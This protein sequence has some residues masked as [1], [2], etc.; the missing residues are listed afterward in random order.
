MSDRSRA[1]TQ[2]PVSSTQ[3]RPT[4]RTTSA[5]RIRGLLSQAGYIAVLPLIILVIWW[6]T[7]LV[8]DSAVFPAPPESIAYLLSDLTD[9]GFQ[10]SVVTTLV[11]LLVGWT[12]AVVVGTLLGF[13]LGQSAFWSAVFET[14]LFALYSIPKV[15]LY[16]I[17]LLLLGIGNTSL[18]AFAFFHGVFP[19]A[20]LV[21]AATRGI[22]P[23]LF[24]L[25][26]GLVL[27]GWQR[28]RL[29]LLPAILPAVVTAVRIGFGLTLLG[30]ILGEMFSSN[31]GLGRELISNVANVQVDRIAGQVVFIAI[32][33]IIPGF[34]LRLLERRVTSKYQNND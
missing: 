33:A 1:T 30:L 6:G 17:F 14:P 28:L 26:S 10:E 21:M 3:A 27:T 31:V 16:P 22:D 34:L 12:L 19:I 29:I 7:A 15:T 8:V 13:V 24:R 4:A 18:V 9:A 5:R 11:L 23:N 32:I 25:A 2:T 20:L